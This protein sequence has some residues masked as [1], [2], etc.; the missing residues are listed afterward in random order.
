MAVIGTFV[1]TKEGG[2]VGTIRTLL[3][4]VKVRFVPND[5][6]A[7]EAAPAFRVFAGDCEVGAAWRKRSV[8][9]EPRAYLSV[10]LPD[11]SM[12]APISAALL[13]LD[14]REESQLVWHEKRARERWRVD[15]QQREEA[16]AR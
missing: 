12:L 4:D 8:G 7:N 15:Q 14:G 10:R 11:P 6:Q 13:T 3:I 9:D 16:N 1:P 2:W 5:N